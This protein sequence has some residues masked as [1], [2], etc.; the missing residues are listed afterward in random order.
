MIEC[1]L[2]EAIKRCK[3]NGGRFS[4]SDNPYNEWWVIND[5]YVVAEGNIYDDFKLEIEDFDRTWI[6]EP[7]KQSAFQKW[8]KEAKDGDGNP[9]Q[10]KDC[11]GDKKEGWNAALD[12]VMREKPFCIVKPELIEAAQEFI[13][14]RRKAIQELKEP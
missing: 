7:P 12:E 4:E 11:F 8:V 1:T 10:C 9:C 3:E 5:K 14:N 6:Y 13:N 2:Q